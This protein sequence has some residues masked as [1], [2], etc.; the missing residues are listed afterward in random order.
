[1]ETRKPN[2]TFERRPMAMRQARCKPG[3]PECCCWF[4]KEMKRSSTKTELT[5]FDEK[6]RGSGGHMQ[7]QAFA[8]QK[9][10]QRFLLGFRTIGSTCV[11]S[12]QVTLIAWFGLHHFKYLKEQLVTSGG[13]NES[14]MSGFIGSKLTRRRT[15][16]M[17]IQ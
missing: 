16:I 13:G 10:H 5:H 8:T 7:I 3:N 4:D 1:M 9:K 2:L 14:T 6:K 17:F 12:C 11:M 15:R